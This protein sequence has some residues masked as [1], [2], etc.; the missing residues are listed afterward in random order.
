MQNNL[1]TWPSLQQSCITGMV[2]K[3]TTEFGCA[4]GNATCYCSDSRFAAGLLACSGEACGAAVESAVSSFGVSYCACKLFPSS[5]DA[6][7]T[8]RVSFRKQL[9]NIV[10]QLLLVLEPVLLALLRPL[11]VLLLLRLPPPP[12][13]LT[14]LP[15]PLLQGKI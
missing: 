15:A 10:T 2:S 7:S 4:V 6:K 11:R 8:E 9:A 3:A 14:P 12:L 1:L 13:P 5:G